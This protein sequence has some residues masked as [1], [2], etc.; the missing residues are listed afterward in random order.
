[1][2]LVARSSTP[3]RVGQGRMVADPF[4]APGK[5]GLNAVQFLGQSLVDP[6]HCH[7]ATRAL[8]SVMVLAEIRGSAGSKGVLRRQRGCETLARGWIMSACRSRHGST[9]NTSSSQA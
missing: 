3:A 5:R 8:L 1:M 6:A 2:L 9:R 7:A 4:V